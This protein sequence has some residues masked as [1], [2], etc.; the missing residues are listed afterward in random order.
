[1]EKTEKSLAIFFLE[2]G[3]YI[4]ADLFFVGEQV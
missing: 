2:L 1:M 4:N 3:L